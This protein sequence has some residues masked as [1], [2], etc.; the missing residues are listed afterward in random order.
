MLESVIVALVKF[1]PFTVGVLIVGLF[2][3]DE[4][5]VPPLITGLVMV[6]VI[7]VGLVN[8]PIEHVGLVIVGVFKVG[9]VITQ[10]VIVFSLKVIE[11]VAELI[12]LE[13]TPA[14]HNNPD[15]FIPPFTNAV[16]FMLPVGFTLGLLNTKL[17]KPDPIPSIN[18]FKVLVFLITQSPVVITDELNCPDPPATANSKSVA[19][20]P[21]P[22]L[23]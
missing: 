22:I 19:L 20:L 11:L 13:V 4:V 17:P 7:I 16:P 14:A 12:E 6:A 5:I 15:N 23:T 2:I 10:F 21:I 1:P 18:K 3:V 8:V 9:E